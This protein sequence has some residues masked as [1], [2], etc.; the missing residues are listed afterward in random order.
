VS[1]LSISCFVS[2]CE[3]DMDKTEM[4]Y[5]LSEISKIAAVNLDFQLY[6]KEKFGGNLSE[7]MNNI[8]SVP[9]VFAFLTPEYKKRLTE[10]RKDS[11]VW[12]EHYSIIHRIEKREREGFSSKDPFLFFPIHIKGSVDDAIPDEYIGRE[13]LADFTKFNVFSKDGEAQVSDKVRRDHRPTL[14]KIA[15][16]IEGEATRLNPL[17]KKYRKEIFESFFKNVKN[18]RANYKGPDR[19]KI[20]SALFVRTRA[21]YS[22][23][24]QSSP[25]LIGR[26]GVGKTTMAANFTAHSPTDYYSSINVEVDDWKL[27]EIFLNVEYVKSQSDFAFVDSENQTFRFA[28]VLFFHLTAMLS[29]VRQS[30]VNLSDDE[31]TALNDLEK[32]IENVS[33]GK[34]PAKITYKA[35]YAFALAK[36]EQFIDQTVQSANGKDHAKF[37]FDLQNNLN[38]SAFIQYVLGAKPVMSLAKILSHDDSR[39]FIFS[40]DRF[41][42]HFEKFRKATLGSFVTDEEY[43]SRSRKE[44]NW[45]Q[46]LIHLVLDIQHF[47]KYSTNLLYS[48]IDFCVMVPKDRFFEIQNATRDSVVFQNNVDEIQ[49]SAI[50]LAIL[51]RKRLEVYAACETKDDYP[52]TTIAKDR[53]TEVMEKGFAQLPTEVVVTLGDKKYPL[54]LFCY[55]LRHTFWRPRDV[56][57][58]YAYILASAMT[59]EKRGRKMEE[60]HVRQQVS[61]ATKEIIRD[62]FIGE[63]ENSI[64]NIKE[65]LSKFRGSSISLSYADI[66]TIL[67]GLDIQIFYRHDRIDTTISKIKL[68]YEIGFLGVRRP[69][70]KSDAEIVNGQMH[71]DAMTFNEDD[72]IIK[73]PDVDEGYFKNKNYIIHPLFSEY[74]ELKTEET[75]LVFNINWAYLFHRDLMAN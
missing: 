23:L 15:E 7:F 33:G 14:T 54:D 8:D 57:V 2:F 21:F 64:T 30:W 63:F 51:L 60:I 70:T 25:I 45:L 29:L 52:A 18:E 75:D 1:N 61:L 20:E 4:E 49:W 62:E 71:G 34:D 10:K 67:F 22:T 3:S 43:E 16:E 36:V 55:V 56:L 74:L 13:Y 24:E 5:L 37:K 47:E 66:E 73:M 59:F 69:L 44:V 19:A 46:A 26:K 68:L 39:R 35:L 32:V 72:E 38:E 48:K 27:H 58:F 17:F 41:D 11:G 50:E 53:L 6:Y 42:T 12:K 31:I 28:W 65:V 40:V 9:V